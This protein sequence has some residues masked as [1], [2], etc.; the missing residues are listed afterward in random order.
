MLICLALPTIWT[1]PFLHHAISRPCVLPLLP[2]L[3]NSRHPLHQVQA[4]Q[5]ATITQQSGNPIGL[6]WVIAQVAIEGG[7]KKGKEGGSKK[8]AAA[9]APE[10]A[11][12]EDTPLEDAPE[13]SGSGR[14]GDD[15]DRWGFECFRCGQDGDLLCCEAR[16]LFLAYA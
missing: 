3:K 12:A 1:A 6:S 16:T 4:A 7:G 14:S 10:Q 11:P 13:A 15:D 9:P 5:T 2:A 8:A